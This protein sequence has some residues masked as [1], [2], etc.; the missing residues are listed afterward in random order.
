MSRECRHIRSILA[1]YSVG[2]LSIAKRD[3]VRKHVESCPDCAAE[4][5][6][7]EAT[8]GLLDR[9]ALEPAPN[10]WEAI[11]AN[12]QPRRRTSRARWWF[13]RHRLQSAIAAT[14]AVAAIAVALLTGNQPSTE[15]EAQTLFA[16]HA[17]MSWREP[18]ADKAAL[19]MAPVVPVATGSEDIP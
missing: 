10:Q 9:A 18:F 6:A 1:D 8:A 7:I 2:N 4:L 15:I 12:L 11:R 14:A 17:S 16:D 3:R 19:G 5:S 13:A